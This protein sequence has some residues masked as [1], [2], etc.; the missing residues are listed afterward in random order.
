MVTYF[1]AR[2]KRA[3]QKAVNFDKLR[4][5]QQEKEENPAHFLSHLTEA[6]R[7][8]TKVDPE[9]LTTPSFS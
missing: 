1:V 3:T 7:C 6:L 5:I 8:Y 4:E 9:T 2:L